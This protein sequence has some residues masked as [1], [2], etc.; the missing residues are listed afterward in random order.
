[1]KHFLYHINNSIKSY[2]NLPALTNFGAETYTYGQMAE[3]IE[4]Y[5]I[6]FEEAGIKKGDKVALYARNSAEWAI[7]Y[8]A[9][10]TYDA[11]TVPFLPDFVLLRQF[12]VFL[13]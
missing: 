2:W 6:F 13:R 8:F 12:F 5:H 3:G 4:K 7:A 9:T 11:V 10:L 1:M